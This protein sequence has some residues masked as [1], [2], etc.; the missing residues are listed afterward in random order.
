[1]GSRHKEARQPHGNNM[2]LRNGVNGPGDLFRPVRGPQASL[3][4]DLAAEQIME[5]IRSGRLAQGSR[6]PPERELAEQLGV[7]R[8]VLR[9]ALRILE[10]AGI[11]TASVGR[12][13]FVTGHAR[14]ENGSEEADLL[15][16][17]RGEI[18]ELNHLLQLVEPE[19]ILE[20]PSHLLPEVAADARA[21]LSRGQ[22]SV[23]GGDAD[24]AAES[25]VEFH[26]A[27][28][29][30]TPNS[31]LR[32]LI[33]RL[34]RSYPDSTRAVYTVE[35]A[36]RRSLAQHQEIVEALEAGSREEAS[37]LLREHAAVAYR[38]AAE[39]ALRS[40]EERDGNGHPSPA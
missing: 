37:R 34:V 13:R 26:L 27:L 32:E 11:F 9:E 39:Q 19:A 30:L 31:M 14:A 6:L 3:L 36:A 4:S 5:L 33:T 20:V 2:A 40:R 8:P 35:A 18:A 17:H 24:A 38:F 29:R 28:C 21:A 10:A 7:S 16:L 1:M 23:D 12:G 22:T 25:D 15:W